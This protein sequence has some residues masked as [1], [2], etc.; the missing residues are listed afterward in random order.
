MKTMIIGGTG[1]ISELVTRRL[2]EA[3]H[4]VFV[5]NR[6]RRSAQPAT[7]ATLVTGDRS[8][9]AAFAA[10]M[11]NHGPYDC[12][13]DM[14]CYNAEQAQVDVDVLGPL[15]PQLIFTSTVDVHRK[16]CLTGYLSLPATEGTEFGPCK[17]F[18]YAL[19]KVACEEVFSRA[20]ERGDLAITTIRPALTYREGSSPF[21]PLW[22]GSSQLD[23]V[24]KGK[25]IILHGDGTTLWTACHSE[26]V[27]VAYVN[28]AGNE[29]AF[30][31]A[32]IVAGDQWMTWEYYWRVV[33]AALGVTEPHFVHIPTDVLVRVAPELANWLPYHF[34]FH[35][36]FDSSAAKR[37]LGFR[38]TIPW[39]EGA[40]RC[41]EWFRGHGGFENSDER[42]EYDQIVNE[43]R[44]AVE[45]LSGRL[46]T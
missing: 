25:P 41:V 24:V 46:V 2:L 15:T 12:V 17:G 42:P 11:K 20:Q 29:A 26:D 35:A 18:D 5:F 28:A 45:D 19:N 10:A 30:G 23:R 32:Y 43:W 33:A 21:H 16:E 6:G 37:E 27:A 1:T 34:Q 14:I 9:V 44:A 31:K 7:G 8:D 4:Q 3:G 39:E 22:G 38:Y 36:I 13:I 40:R